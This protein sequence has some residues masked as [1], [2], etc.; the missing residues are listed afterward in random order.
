[1]R[2]KQY[3]T[4]NHTGPLTMAQSWRH[5]TSCP[6]S[7]SGR[8]IPRIMNHSE[9]RAIYQNLPLEVRTHSRQDAL[10]P[11]SLQSYELPVKTQELV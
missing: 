11:I 7:V 6:H 8:H 3:W 9:P 1:M 2:T 4:Q 10:S 5:L